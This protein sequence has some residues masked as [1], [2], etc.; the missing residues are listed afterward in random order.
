[1]TG[2]VMDWQPIETMPEG[3]HILLFWPDGEK[4]VGG[5][6]CATV[7][8]N[9]DVPLG[10]IGWSYWTHGGPN[11]GLDWEPRNDE[12]PTHWMPLPAPPK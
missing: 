4:G 5:I 7:Y 9:D 8:K 3:Q 12:R 10:G 11:S 1:M 2:M 6:E